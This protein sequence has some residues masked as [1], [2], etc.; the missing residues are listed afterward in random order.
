MFQLTMDSDW[1]VWLFQWT[2]C[3]GVSIDYLGFRANAQGDCLVFQ[4]TLW[5]GMFRWTGWLYVFQ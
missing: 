1:L 5:F 2:G 4:W 3:L